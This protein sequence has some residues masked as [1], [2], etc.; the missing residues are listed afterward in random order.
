MSEVLLD[1]LY[2]GEK[3]EWF[4]VF[5][6]EDPSY[7]V[8]VDVEPVYNFLGHLMGLEVLEVRAII[9]CFHSGLELDVETWDLKDLTDLHPEAEQDIMAA[10]KNL[11][12]EVQGE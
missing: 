7:S 9:Y 4:E 1:F 5:R 3:A 2:E 8:D 12:G 10:F 6:G 11:Y